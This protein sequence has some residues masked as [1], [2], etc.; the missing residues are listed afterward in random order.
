MFYSTASGAKALVAKDCRVLPE[1]YTEIALTGRDE[2]NGFNADV[3]DSGAIERLAF[4]VKAYLCAQANNGDSNGYG[5]GPWNISS[6]FSVTK[7][8][9]ISLSSDS[10]SLTSTAATITIK[11]WKRGWYYKLDASGTTNDV[12]VVVRFRPVGMRTTLAVWLP[13][14]PIPL[15]LGTTRSSM[16]REPPRQRQHPNQG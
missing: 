5:I 6:V 2:V 12:P 3:P 9:G 15:P 8:S 14:H 10:D 11:N 7:P 16:R 13:T 4:T 1:D